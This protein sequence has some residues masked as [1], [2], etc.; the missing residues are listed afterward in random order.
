M[1]PHRPALDEL[2]TQSWGLV[3]IIQLLNKD[4]LYF[5]EK[6]FMLLD[7]SLRDG[8]DFCGFEEGLT[9]ELYNQGCMIL[10]VF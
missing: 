10:Y 2:K 8:F 6:I 3:E 7:E 1:R 5:S 4:L 9:T